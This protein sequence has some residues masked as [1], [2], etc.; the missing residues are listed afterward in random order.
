M[1]WNG[2][3]GRLRLVRTEIYGADDDSGLGALAQS[4]G[5]APQV[6]RNIEQIGELITAGQLL[7]FIELTGVNP[8]WLLRGQ[9]ARY[10]DG[11]GPDGRFE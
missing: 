3:G 9:G 4:L 1:L 10:R 5:I 8:V 6:W 7:S 2:L 11:R